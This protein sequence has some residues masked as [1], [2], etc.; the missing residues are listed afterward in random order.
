MIKVQLLPLIMV[1]VHILYTFEICAK[2]LLLGMLCS[3]AVLS[4]SSF[5]VIVFSGFKK[6]LIVSYHRKMGYKC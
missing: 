3:A 5:S 6:K 2:V 4:E 1:T